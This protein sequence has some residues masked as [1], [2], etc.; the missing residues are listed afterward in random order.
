[1]ASPWFPLFGRDFIAA[2][3]GW[4]A[5]ERGHYVTLL[6]AQW[7]QGGLPNDPKRLELISPG[8]GKVWK[9][10]ESKFPIS[11][12]GQRRNTRLEHERHLSE[13]RSEKARQSAS[14]GWEKRRAAGAPKEA[15]APEADPDN[16]AENEVSGCDRICEGTCDG[17][18][19][20]DASMTMTMSYSPP[21]PP[22]AGIL[23]TEEE[24]AAWDRLQGAWNAAWGE[25][26]RWGSVDPPP[27]AIGLLRDPRRLE[28]AIA[29]IPQIKAGACSGFDSPPTL[30]QFV[31]VDEKGLSFVARML[32][33]EFRDKSLQRKRRE[34]PA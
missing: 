17:I 29:A 5:E 16:L 11:T 30:R 20:G 23:E 24:V 19:P 32:G 2:T 7:E 6:V 18:C 10:I 9:T 12:G 21:P 4:T 27:E 1:M 26:R 15:A 14:A 3:M 25:K 31:A 8:V 28:E 33:G 22:S 34:V 13:Q